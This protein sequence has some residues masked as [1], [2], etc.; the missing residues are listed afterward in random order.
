MSRGIKYIILLTENLN[1]EIVDGLGSF[2]YRRVDGR[3]NIDNV[4]MQAK[5]ALKEENSLSFKYVGFRLVR[6]SISSPVEIYK[7]IDQDLLSDGC[8]E[9]AA[10]TNRKMAGVTGNGSPIAT[11]LAMEASRSI[12]G[13]HESSTHWIARL[14]A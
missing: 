6:G 7:Y 5:D 8:K 3:L 9:K 2:A 4:I 11:R 14:R 10:I 12:D 13:E 1:Q